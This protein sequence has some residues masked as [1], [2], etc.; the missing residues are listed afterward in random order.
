M[1]EC[2]ATH[3]LRTLLQSAPHFNLLILQG[4]LLLSAS[5]CTIRPLIPLLRE[6][7][8]RLESVSQPED[9]PASTAFSL[10]LLPQP[11]I[12]EGP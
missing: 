4:N 11:V 5:Y 7:Q 6:I 3:L 9:S 1:L 10:L 8:T 2:A 12:M